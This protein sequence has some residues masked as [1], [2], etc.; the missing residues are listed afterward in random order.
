MKNWLG[1]IFVGLSMPAISQTIGTLP[2]DLSIDKGVA[3]YQIPLT[4][5]SGKGGI[6]PS[7]AVSYSSSGPARSTLG[8]GFVLN[9]L[10]SIK[11][12]GDHQAIEG[13]TSSVTY[14]LTDNFCLNGTRLIGTEGVIGK[15]GSKYRLHI[16]SQSK[17]TLNGDSST[18]TSYFVKHDKNGAVE[19]Y[20]YNSLSK[21]WLLSS[22]KSNP[23]SESIAYN[24]DDLG[25][26]SSISY[27]S[28]NIAFNYSL[29]NKV[30]PTKHFKM[31]GRVQ[32]SESNLV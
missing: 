23:N 32:T 27:D 9:G 12:C 1:V 31:D 24:Y 25:Q 11:R 3:Y 28:F 6:T 15:D 5:P 30:V 4:F 14:S 7:L 10:S 17:I 18:L 8:A 13:G 20:R 16:D 21:S 19:E 29:V 26:I 22:Y 2:G